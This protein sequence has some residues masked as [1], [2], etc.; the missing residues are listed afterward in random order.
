[1]T[2]GLSVLSPVRILEC[3]PH[4]TLG[5][6]RLGV[7]IARAGLGKSA[8]LAQLGLWH[9]SRG[10]AVIHITLNASA[11]NV[12]AYYQVLLKDMT[13]RLGEL[14]ATMDREA[15]ERHKLILVYKK[16]SFA[17]E[18][19][20][21]QLN[22]LAAKV[23][24]RAAVFLVDG[25]DFEDTDAA[26]FEDFQTLARDEGAEVWFSALGHRHVQMVNARGIPYPCH[27]CDRFFDLILA[28]ETD[29]EGV[30]LR[31]LKDREAPVESVGPV[32]LDP[33]TFLAAVR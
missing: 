5:P 24:F 25:L 1:M 21:Q 17:V 31:L 11:E 9:A 28:M 30:V 19:L 32:R 15:L 4:K 2:D 16:Q 33:N 8:F 26:V 13:L 12:Q 23:G 14:P 22:D 3:S 29:A 18:R 7:V 27:A 6:G 10:T 20:R